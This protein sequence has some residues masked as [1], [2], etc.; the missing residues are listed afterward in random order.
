[1][2]VKHHIL[3]TAAVNVGEGCVTFLHFICRVSV[4]I[5]TGK[6][7]GWTQIKSGHGRKERKMLYA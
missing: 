5:L 3:L 4:F 1:V 7:C 2:E 6:E